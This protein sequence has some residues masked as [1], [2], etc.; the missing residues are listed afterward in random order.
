MEQ[1]E[2]LLPPPRNAKGHLCN[3]RRSEILRGNGVGVQLIFR[4]II[5]IIA[6]W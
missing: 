2:Q 4:N 6:T 3:S 5:K 1:M